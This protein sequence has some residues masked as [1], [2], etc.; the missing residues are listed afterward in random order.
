MQQSLQAWEIIVMG[1]LLLLS[2]FF[3]G[4]ETALLSV[5]KLRLRHLAEDGHK[6]AQRV[7]SLINKPN[8]FLA[9]VLV[10]N[11]IVNTGAAALATTMIT[12]MVGGGARAAL[13]ATAVVTVLLLVFGEIT[14][15]TFAS[16]NSER[17]AFRV[18]RP[19]SVVMAILMPVVQL[20]TAITN[21]V[22]KLL[23]SRVEK[24]GPFVTQ[25]EIRTLVSVGEEEG[26]LE[27]AE[28]EMIDSIFEFGD[29]EASQVMVP[30]IDIDSIEA[31]APLTE[32]LAI[33]NE[34]GHSRIPVYEETIDNIIGILYAKDL[35]KLVDCGELSDK[36]ARNIMRPAHYIPETKRVDDLLREMQRKKVHIAIVLDEYGGTAGLVTIEDILEEIVGDIRDEYDLE[37]PTIQILSDGAVLADARVGI[38]EINEVLETSL[39]EEEFETISGLIFNLFG[40]VP[41]KGETIE[42]EDLTITVA[43]IVGRRITRVKLEKK[44][45]G[46]GREDEEQAHET[47]S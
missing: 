30:R 29:T 32:A 47:P 28:R 31:N 11:N 35:L 10:G 9:S 6:G 13:L 24:Q 46:R 23:G 3:S 41:K 16:Q 39:P 8:R 42:F 33:I 18:A 44:P 12:K 15:K 14:P 27:E 19:I 4:S 37:E 2:A 17:V 36:T 45:P 20:L 43:D 40:R 25:E 7:Q 26:V 5:N 34:V 22:I 38:D 21:L 1:L